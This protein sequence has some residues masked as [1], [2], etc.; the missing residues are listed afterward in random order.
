VRESE[1]RGLIGIVATIWPDPGLP[2]E[3]EH[4]WTLELCKQRFEAEDLAAGIRSLATT[5]RFRPSL[6]ELCDVA[7]DEWRV[8]IAAKVIPIL[9]RGT[10]RPILVG[11]DHSPVEDPHDLYLDL[12]PGQPAISKGEWYENYATPEERRKANI[13]LPKFF[14]RFGIDDEELE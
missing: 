7:E 14:A 1:A 2:E 13:Y 8:R 5:N 11:R 12:P 10:Y 3:T 6:A 9:P 4:L